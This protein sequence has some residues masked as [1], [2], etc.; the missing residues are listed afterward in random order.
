MSDELQNATEV[1]AQPRTFDLSKRAWSNNYDV[2]QIVN[3]GERLHLCVWTVENLKVGDYLILKN[4]AGTTRYQ[5]ENVQRMSD[6]PDQ[7]FVDVVF[8][9]REAPAG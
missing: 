4:G 2:M 9:P 3:N 7:S 6:P 8:A 5:I 1:A